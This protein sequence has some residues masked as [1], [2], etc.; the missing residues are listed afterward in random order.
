M[1]KQSLPSF[2]SL[3]PEG[4]GA[5][6]DPFAGADLVDVLPG[7]QGQPMEPFSATPAFEGQPTP[8]PAAADPFAGADIVDVQKVTEGPNQPSPEAFPGA[9]IVPVPGH[10]TLD[11]IKS[12]ELGSLISD[13]NFHPSEF[14]AQNLKALQDDPNA[15]QKVLDVYTQRDKKDGLATVA[16][17]KS[18]GGAV[19]HPLKTVG[20]AIDIVKGI[21]KAAL[22]APVKPGVEAVKAALQ[23]KGKEVSK[24]A[25]A[26]AAEIPEAIDP[27]VQ[28]FSNLGINIT[29][30]FVEDSQK[31]YRA[32]SG[33]K[34]ELT[35]EEYKKR[36]FLDAERKHVEQEA[37]RGNGEIAQSLGV[38]ADELADVG[39]QVDPEAIKNWQTLGETAAWVAMGNAVG[40]V[41]SKGAT[42]LARTSSPGIAQKLASTLNSATQAVAEGSFRGPGWIIERLGT[43]AEAVGGRVAGASRLGLARLAIGTAMRLGGRVAQAG[44]EALQAVAPVAGKVTAE[45]AAGAA[46]AAAFTYPLM[47]GATPEEREAM[48]GIIGLGALARGVPAVGRVIKEDVLPR[49]QEALAGQIFKSVERADIPDSAEYGTDAALDRAH[50]QQMSRTADGPANVLNYMRE[51]FRKSGIEI[52]N[53]DRDT[54]VKQADNAAGAGAAKGFFVNAGEKALPDGSSLPVTQIFLNGGTD[55][56]S[57]ELYHAFATLDPKGA[58]PLKK[59]IDQTW[60]PEEKE[61]LRQIYEGSL[62]RGI[63]PEDPGYRRLSDDGLLEEAAAEVFGRVLEST[64]LTGVAPTIQKRAATFLSKALDSIGFPLRARGRAAGTGVSELGIRPGHQELKTSQEFIRNLTARLQE[65]GTIIPTEPVEAAPAKEAAPEVSVVP[66]PALT[67]LPSP[68]APAEVT[69]AAPPAPAA[70]VTP[71]AVAPVGAP[72][73]AVPPV[74]PPRPPS[75]RVTEK[76]RSD[77]EAARAAVTNKPVAENWVE[78]NGTPEQKAAVQSINDALDRQA[79]VEIVYESAAG[80]GTAAKPA[81]RTQRRA[82]VEAGRAP[83]A[84]RAL[85]TKRLFVTRWEPIKKTGEPQLLAHDADKVL[86]NVERGIAMARAAGEE[87]PWEVDAEGKL[88]P[89]GFREVLNDQKTYWANQDAGHRGGGGKF[90]RP[91]EVTGL[92]DIGASIPER[93]GEGIPLDADPA[94]NE[95]KEQFLNLFQGLAEPKTIREEAGKV[96]GNVK[97]QVLAK[98]QGRTPE[99]PAGTLTPADVAATF[100]G[101]AIKDPELRKLVAGEAL[102]ITNPLRNRLAAAGQPVRELIDTTERV[103]LSRIRSAEIQPD[104]PGGGGVTDIMRAGFL[105]G[106]PESI[107]PEGMSVEDFSDRLLALAPK[108]WAE[109]NTTFPGG[110]TGGAY[111]LGLNLKNLLQVE[112]LA[113]ARD[114]ASDRGRA[115]MKAGNLTEAFPEITKSQFFREAVEAATDSGS[116]GNPTGGWRR[117]FPD[118]QAP[119][120]EQRGKFLPAGEEETKRFTVSWKPKKEGKTQLNQ[121]INANT[122]QEALEKADLPANAHV[123]SVTPAPRNLMAGGGKE[124]LGYLK[125]KAIKEGNFLPALGSDKKLKEWLG[126]SKVP[127]VYH[128]SEAAP[129]NFSEKRVGNG[130]TVLGNYQIERYGIFASENPE[131]ANEFAGRGS[132]IPLNLK[133]ERP[134][135]LTNS[136]PGYTDALFKKVEEYGDEKFAGTSPHPGYHLARALGDKWGPNVW[137][138]FDTDEHNNPQDWIDLFKSLGFDGI[139]FDEP[140]TNQS[141]STSWVAFKPEQVRNRLKGGKFSAALKLEELATEEPNLTLVP[142]TIPAGVPE[143]PAVPEGSPLAA[144]AIAAGGTAA[145]QNQDEGKFLPERERSYEDV[146]KNFRKGISGRFDD[147]QVARLM[148]GGLTAEQFNDLPYTDKKIINQI[149]EHIQKTQPRGFTVFYPKNQGVPATG[150]AREFVS[151]GFRNAGLDTEATA[152]EFKNTP[153]ETFGSKEFLGEVIDFL[154]IETFQKAGGTEAVKKVVGRLSSGESLDSIYGTIAADEWPVILAAIRVWQMK[155]HPEDFMPVEEALREIKDRLAEKYGAKVAEQVL[156]KYGPRVLPGRFLPEKSEEPLTGGRAFAKFFAKTEETPG[157][158]AKFSDIKEVLQKPIKGL[159]PELESYLKYGS[160]FQKHIFTSIPGFIDARLRLLKGLTDP[161]LFPEGEEVHFLDL[162]SSEGYYPKAW[163]ELAQKNGIDASSV[164]M[165]PSPTFQKSFERLPQ[166]KNAEFSLSAF[167]QGFEDPVSGKQIPA[168]EP[169]EKKF[170]IVHEGMTFQ[171]FTADRAENFDRVKALMTPDGVFT[172]LEKVKNPDYAAREVLKDQFKSQFYSQDQLAAKSKEVLKKSD[173][174]AVGMLSYQVPRLDLEKALTDRWKHVVQIWSSGNFAGYIASD[175]LGVVKRLTKAIG[176]TSTK[177]SVEETPREVRGTFSPGRSE[178]ATTEKG[179]ALESKGFD[180]VPVG[181]LANRGI[182][183]RRKGEVVGEISS[184]RRSPG[185]AEIVM[186]KVDPDQRR[187]G[188]GEVLYRELGNQ[189]KADDVTKVTGITVHPA[190]EAARKKVF[191]ETTETGSMQIEPG[192]TSKLLESKITPESRFLPSRKKKEEAGLTGWIL[193]D[194]KFVKL[195]SGYHENYLADNFEALNKKYGT[196]FSDQPDVGERLKALNRGFVRL[197]RDTSGNLH[198]E[199]NSKYWNGR[200][201]D[202]ILSRAL[203]NAD[204]INNFQVSLLNDKGK[205]IDSQ[206]ANLFMADDS[207]EAVQNVVDNIR[208]GR[209]LPGAQDQ[210]EKRIKERRAFIKNTHPEAVIPEYSKDEN[211]NY[212]VDKEGDPIPSTTPY[213][214]MDT[215]KAKELARD[216]RDPDAKENAVVDYAAD[217]LVKDARQAIKNPEIKAGLDWYATARIKIKELFGDDSKLFCELLAAT[218]PQTG[219]ETNYKFALEA[220]NS[221]KDGRFEGQID[222]YREGIRKW[223]EGDIADFEAENP[224]VPAAQKRAKFFRWWETTNGLG[225]T[226]SNGKKFGMNSRAVL[227][228]LSDSWEGAQ[229]TRQFVGNLSGTSF[230]ATIDIWAARTLHRL[231]NEDSGKRWRLTFGHEQGVEK[232]DFDFAQKAYRRAAEKLNL[233]PDALQALIWFSEKHLWADRGWTKNAGAEKSDYNVLLDITKPAEGGKKVLVKPEDITKK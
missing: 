114:G 179:K 187:K 123:V 73:P 71:E 177:F 56:L 162:G 33:D 55:G 144:A 151:A 62:N 197:R 82:E 88:T 19:I 164:A 24:I 133:I 47:I 116:A 69:P 206:S 75:I 217:K 170:N 14:A 229:K 74:I 201:K 2:S 27:I 10:Y 67:V 111:A 17:A 8:A 51:L 29:R 183:V 147:Q 32:A 166:V 87:V 96:P 34:A 113:R 124:L 129:E 79:G 86:S 174:Q 215:P 198:V 72:P 53:L 65:R 159:E 48:T 231:L 22:T 70:P 25:A 95:R 80:E 150:P 225:V 12:T 163:T 107:L 115:L 4:A 182:E 106:R 3:T 110:L 44:G 232:A 83:G 78:K 50:D 93:T 139:K 119:F 222:K 125:D 180:I 171:F 200:V 208:G 66:A 16:A 219:V 54:F 98:I 223:N 137:K 90:I 207:S 46:H 100:K 117:L 175:D 152:T 136:G 6:P 104:L 199:L 158:G 138:I 140:N 178:G 165:D 45:T 43:G 134:L 52:Y 154:P 112:K 40:A 39:V 184:A 155:N 202:A 181:G 9:D 233:Q 5:P 38:G 127:V 64:D 81:A 37:A 76:Q 224:K 205:V 89:A 156:E 211:G 149:A 105:P 220:Y 94:R 60:T 190:A 203:D 84:E 92:G 31:L 57:H 168:F 173:E 210:I 101:E 148:D 1:P 176:D 189:L 221:F 185:E 145:T 121:V 7:L 141:N 59:V 186:V 172:V 146:L 103:N 194:Q 214:F 41:G 61:S 157:G 130:S 28:G 68:I 102:K 143:A 216:H 132:V 42:V 196:N 15:L 227:Q 131:V 128:G 167:G 142:P 23:G 192:E 191:P 212:K 120:P 209:Y 122:E 213:A 153:K 18:L 230:E 20:G 21:A 77:L 218:S 30:G 195:D 204:D 13:T 85:Q 135:D 193:P 35:P 108:E 99:V 161:K 58:E 26:R 226:Q 169:G 91:T 36:F 49:G 63:R 109:I 11:S 160:N 228:V 126:D 188:L 118:A 97:A